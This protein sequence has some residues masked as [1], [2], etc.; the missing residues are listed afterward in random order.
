MKVDDCYNP[1][2]DEAGRVHDWRNYISEE[3]RAIWPTFT[4]DQKKIIAA[5]ADDEAGNEHWE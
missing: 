1:K 3:M 5:N 2:W 4:D